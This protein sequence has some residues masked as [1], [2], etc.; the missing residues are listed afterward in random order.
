MKGLGSYKQQIIKK[1]KKD[2]NGMMVV[3]AVLSFTVFIVA[4]L[5]IVFLIDIFIIHNKIQFALNSSA[6]ELA[7]YSY[8]YQVFG[9]RSADQT[10]G[11]DGEEFTNPIDATASQTVDFLNKLQTFKESAANVQN[12]ASQFEWNPS[13]W[14]EHGQDVVDSASGAIDAAQDAFQSGN[15]VAERFKETFGDPQKLLTGIIYMG[16]SLVTDKVMKEGFAQAS[17]DLLVKKYLGGDNADAVLRAYGVKDGIK[18]LD[19]SGSSMFCD[20][21]YKMIDLVVSYDIDM[22]FLSLIVPENLHVVQRVTVPAWLD[23]DG[24]TY[25]GK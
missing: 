20:S 24:V 25:D 7:S 15:E 22:N 11:K 18:G 12:S 14:Y 4:V 21:D 19:Y 1:L 3:E 17:A 2:Q 23:G 5:A 6:H 16:T 8:M 9:V 10:L 13:T